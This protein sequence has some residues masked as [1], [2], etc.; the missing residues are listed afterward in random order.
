MEEAKE[1]TIRIKGE[2]K[3]CSFKHLIYDPIQCSENDLILRNLL[4]V[5]KEEF[6]GEIESI[7]VTIKM[8]IVC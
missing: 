4:F 2:D 8:E 3:S 6:V 5:A 7:L 1:I